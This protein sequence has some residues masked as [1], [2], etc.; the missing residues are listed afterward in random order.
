MSEHERE[1]SGSPGMLPLFLRAGAALV[2]GAS[3]LPFVSG[4]GGGEMPDLALVLGDVATDPDRLSA[5]NRVC[6]FSLRD[7]LPATYPHMLAFPLHLA[8]M[9]DGSFPFPAVGLVHIANRITQHR[10]VRP[11]ERL[12]LRVHAGPLEPHPRG[13]QFPIITE[14][15]VGDQ[16]VWE[17]AS[18]NLRRGSGSGSGSDADAA[19]DAGATPLEEGTPEE[20]PA[21]AQWRLPD[22]AAGDGRVRRGR[23]HRRR[24]LRGSGHEDADP[25]PRR[26]AVLQLNVQ[27][28]PRRWRRAGLGVDQARG[29]RAPPG[30]RIPLGGG[31]AMGRD[32]PVSRAVSHQNTRLAVGRHD[33]P[34]PDVCVME[35]ASMLAGERFS[36]RPVSVCP[37]VGAILR[38]YNDVTDEAKRN[39]LYRYAAESVG[40]R[41]DFTLR[42]R[43]AETA[44]AWA[45]AE[46]SRSALLRRLVRSDRTPDPDDGPDLVA[47]YVVDALGRRPSD[48]G[49]AAMLALI[50]RLIA[51]HTARP[52]QERAPTRCTSPRRGVRRWPVGAS[53]P[54]P[55]TRICW[56]S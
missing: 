15:R 17:E 16:L 12:S 13:R 23:H 36:D 38:A 8:L 44:I 4:S 53:S 37:V 24:S 42:R 26:A 48:H 1:L 47:R 25:A 54:A 5:Y 30:G 2:P 27:P 29:R 43:R 11:G 14:A 55:H 41:G 51:M 34:G 45:V 19:G 31:I 32:G 6:G 56:P 9:T 52:D 46:R 49:H 22:P 7:E 33:R 35:L 39:D 3:R 21:T 50:D 10:P 20:L 28:G 40:T 18:V